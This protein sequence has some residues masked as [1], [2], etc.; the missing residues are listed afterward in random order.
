[1][2]FEDIKE[3]IKK[4]KLSKPL[5]KQCIILA[6]DSYDIGVIEY[7]HKVKEAIDKLDKYKDCKDYDIGWHEAL[8]LLNKE[9]GL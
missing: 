9:L 4:A 2:S 8:E 6:K 1:M 7:K 3:R 5:E